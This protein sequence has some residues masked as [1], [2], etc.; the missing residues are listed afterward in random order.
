MNGV[1]CKSLKRP[2]LLKCLKD[3]NDITHEWGLGS[4]FGSLIGLEQEM[5]KELELELEN[6]I[7]QGL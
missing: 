5:A 7:L 3:R 1:Q 4:Y 2:D 6:F